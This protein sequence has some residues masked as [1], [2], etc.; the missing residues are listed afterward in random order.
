MNVTPVQ[1]PPTQC[2]LYQYLNLGAFHS[3][4]DKEKLSFHR[5]EHG[6]GVLK[7][8]N[9][10]ILSIKELPSWMLLQVWLQWGKNGNCFLYFDHSGNPNLAVIQFLP[11]IP[12]D[13]KRWIAGYLCWHVTST[14]RGH[15]PSNR[16]L[17][18][19]L[20]KGQE[21]ESPSLKLLT[22]CLS[23]EVRC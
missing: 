4:R 11:F 3:L 16:N 23:E 13:K 18:R 15:H 5:I 1:F 21:G 20:I 19:L 7:S 17:C 8:N 22:G 6:V 10:L 12:P 14:S 9:P 2:F